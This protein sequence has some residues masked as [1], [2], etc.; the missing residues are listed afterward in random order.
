MKNPLEKENR[1][2]SAIFW[3]ER[4]KWFSDVWFDIKGRRQLVNNAKSRSRSAAFPFELAYRLINMYSLKGDTIL[5]PF[6]GTGT[7]NLAA[8]VAGRNSIGIE[9]DSEFLTLFNETLLN[10]KSKSSGQ[11]LKR[12]KNHI[13]F[14]EH[15][16]AAGIDIKHKNKYYGFPVITSQEKNILLDVVKSIDP[17]GESFTATCRPLIDISEIETEQF[18]SEKAGQRSLFHAAATS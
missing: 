3:E 7:T 17:N 11:V 15:R 1:Q 2:Q 6:A 8:V 18:I 4:N 13:E 9:I 5:D 16:L 14:V 10:G 12:L